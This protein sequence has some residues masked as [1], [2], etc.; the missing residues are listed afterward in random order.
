MSAADVAYCVRFAG[1]CCAVVSRRLQLG[2]ELLMGSG[3]CYRAP[4]VRPSP[5]L[6][7][8]FQGRE[9]RAGALRGWW[10][11]Q[12]NRT[13]QKAARLNL[14]AAG[15]SASFF[16]LPSVRDIFGRARGDFMFAWRSVG[17]TK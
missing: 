6:A 8:R 17:A 10:S 7:P 12:W 11:E 16:A 5:P 2:V 1:S 9:G 15:R 4:G 14:R 3:G 13:F